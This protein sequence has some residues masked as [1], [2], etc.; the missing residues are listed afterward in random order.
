[1]QIKWS[2]EIG[3]LD[4]TMTGGFNLVSKTKFSWQSVLW[5]MTALIDNSGP[6]QTLYFCRAEQNSTIK[7]GRSTASATRLWHGSDLEV[8]LL[9]CQT[10]FINYIYV[11]WWD[12]VFV[13]WD[14][15]R[16]FSTSWIWYDSR[17]MSESKLCFCRAFAEPN[18]NLVRH[19]KS[20]TSELGLSAFL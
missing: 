14:L 7:H 4:V 11:F 9:P 5:N 8:M 6:V 12:C 2:V 17:K 16:G 15:L 1:M 10:N 20:T 3:L 18:C 19:G 13:G